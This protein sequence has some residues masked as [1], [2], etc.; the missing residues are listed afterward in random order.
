VMAALFL[1][2]GLLSLVASVGEAASMHRSIASSRDDAWLSFPILP[3]ETPYTWDG[4]EWACDAAGAVG[5]HDCKHYHSGRLLSS[6]GQ[7][8]DLLTCPSGNWLLSPSSEHVSCDTFIAQGI[9][10]EGEYIEC[11]CLS[12]TCETPDGD[13][14]KV[15][16]SFRMDVDIPT[17]SDGSVVQTTI[18]ETRA[19]Y[20]TY[21]QV[22]F[23]AIKDS[24]AS[25]DIPTLL[26]ASNQHLREVSFGNN[27]PQLQ[28]ETM[29]GLH[30]VK[31]KV[32]KKMPT[33]GSSKAKGKTGGMAKGKETGG[34]YVD[35]DNID[36]G[37]C[38]Q[39]LHFDNGDCHDG[40]DPKHTTQQACEADPKH[41]WCGDGNGVA[42][43]LS[44]AVNPSSWLTP[45]QHV[46]A[47]PGEEAMKR[48]KFLIAKKFCHYFGSDT[49][50]DLAKEAAV[51]EHLY[52]LTVSN[53][54][55]FSCSLKDSSMYVKVTALEP[56]AAVPSHGKL[57]AGWGLV[58]G[59]SRGATAWDLDALDTFTMATHCQTTCQK[60]SVGEQAV[61]CEIRSSVCSRGRAARKLLDSS[62]EACSSTCQE[63]GCSVCRHQDHCHTGSSETPAKC[64]S[65]DKEWCGGCAGDTPDQIEAEAE[66][67]VAA[68]SL[69]CEADI[70]E[71]MCAEKVAMCSS[72]LTP[73]TYQLDTAKH[74][75]EADETSPTEEVLQVLQGATPSGEL[76]AA[77]A[78]TAEHDYTLCQKWEC[79]QCLHYTDHINCHQDQ[80]E[81]HVTKAACE[82]DPKHMWCG[83]AAGT[84]QGMDTAQ[85]STTWRYEAMGGGEC[86]D[87]S[88][89]YATGG[90]L[91]AP[92]E[93][94]AHCLA[95]APGVVAFH[96]DVHG[97]CGC[98]SDHCTSRKGSTMNS[99]IAYRIVDERHLQRTA[100]LQAKVEEATRQALAEFRFWT[101]KQV[102]DSQ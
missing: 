60:A 13:M 50:V 27:P 33:L 96:V 79:P 17:G 42:Q 72:P 1:S 12:E 49:I 91:T 88:A 36:C 48:L 63:V 9:P 78:V 101:S 54:N 86:E 76:G 43:G 57:V 92:D 44:D 61:T 47:L 64:S 90:G 10:C 56:G 98:S 22:R 32:K 93:C 21:M 81:K 24:F 8:P 15:Y 87:T 14:A 83:P 68:T 80:K 94:L 31:G 25:K 37:D 73:F 52:R 82:A 100:I 84:M 28:P 5:M 58:I 34:T 67:D 45:A 23:K 29:T 30:S 55:R 46:D 85:D 11:R 20:M 53:T 40:M 70:N 77:A 66:I 19:E 35:R 4:T 71:A 39:C 59:A 51:G 69:R 89:S 97:G 75:E 65:H 95:N 74:C 26:G 6:A 41:V 102:L 18:M 16:A 7:N 99:A 38:K 3:G 62:D 2:A